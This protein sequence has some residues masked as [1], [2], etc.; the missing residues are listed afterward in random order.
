[1]KPAY[2]NQ[3]SVESPTMTDGLRVDHPRLKEYILNG[4]K[5]GW[6]NEKI[7]N[8]VNSDKKYLDATISIVDKVRH[9][10]EKEKKNME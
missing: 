3:V 4:V 7:V 2:A 8:M 5:M 9:Q 1:M 10:Y 6:R